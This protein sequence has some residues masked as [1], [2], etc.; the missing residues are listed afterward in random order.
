VVNGEAEVVLLIR[1][2]ASSSLST[3]R[4]GRGAHGLAAKGG[5]VVVTSLRNERWSLVQ[6]AEGKSRCSSRPCG[7]SITALRRLSDEIYFVADYGNVDNV[8][9]WRAGPPASRAGPKRGTASQISAPV[10]ANCS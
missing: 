6:I 1:R 4:A 5:P 9:S 10:E 2:A 7:P 3:A 8:W